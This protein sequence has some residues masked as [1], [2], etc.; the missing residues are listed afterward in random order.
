MILL[1]FFENSRHLGILIYWKLISKFVNF[2]NNII[3]LSQQ[4]V[5][6]TVSIT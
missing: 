6:K 3:T 4:L 5:A 2:S 1:V